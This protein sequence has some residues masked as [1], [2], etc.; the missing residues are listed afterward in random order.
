MLESALETLAHERDREVELANLK[1][2][3]VSMT[4]HEFRTPL[5]V[6]LSSAELLEAYGPRWD[7]SKKQTH[8][9]RIQEASKKMSQ[10]L[11]G[12]LLIGRAESGMLQANPR[13]L[14]PKELAATVV[15][16]VCLAAGKDRR[17]EYR[18]RG[19]S[20]AMWLDENLLRHVLTNLLTN[21][22]KYSPVGSTVSFV[23]QQEPDGVVFEV[24]DEGIGIP[25]GELDHL[26]EAFHRCSNASAIPGTG[27]GLAVVKKSVDVHQGTIEVESR[28]GSGTRFAVRLPELEEAA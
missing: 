1:S 4:S 19:G 12:V 23:V 17:L 21:A 2:R 22:F 9:E 16:E 18:E 15:E 13:R 28:V 11:D 10:M 24:A 8:L 26:F 3:F 5:S 7:E 25:E 20:E 27:L 6:I 14:R